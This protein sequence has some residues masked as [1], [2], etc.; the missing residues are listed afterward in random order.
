MDDATVAWIVGGAVAVVI[1]FALYNVF[2]RKQKKSIFS[3]FGGSGGTG[4]GGTDDSKK[5][6]VK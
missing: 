2:F 4:D 1:L 6:R 3:M 5:R